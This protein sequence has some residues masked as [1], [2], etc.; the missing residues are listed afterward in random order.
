MAV[1]VG[2]DFAL[3]VTEDGNICSCGDNW[4][5]QLGIGDFELHV[6]PCL[7]KYVDTFDGHEVVMVAARESRS[8]CVTK[9]GTLWTWGYNGYGVLGH[10]HPFDWRDELQ[11]RPRRLSASLLGDSPVLMAAY[12]KAFLLILTSSGHVWS[13]GIGMSYELGHGSAEVNVVP[14][15]IDPAVFDNAEI[16]MIAAGSEHCIALSKTGGKVWGWGCNYASQTGVHNEFVDETTQCVRT[17]TLIPATDLQGGSVVFVS[18]GWDSS[19]LVT[20]D[21]VLWMCGDNDRYG[22]GMGDDIAGSH[23]FRR[24]GGAEFFGTGIRMVA[25]GMHHTMILANDNTVWTCGSGECGEL[26]RAPNWN[27]VTAEQVRKRGPPCRID[28]TTFYQSAPRGLYDNDAAVVAVGSY[29]SF[30]ITNGGTVYFW[31]CQPRVYFA[32]EQQPLD[33]PAWGSFEM[34]APNLGLAD[35]SVEYA[36]AGLWHYMHQDAMIAFV[37]GT[38]SSFAADTPIPS[39]STFPPEM[40]RQLFRNMRLA[41]REPTSPGVRAL[42]GIEDDE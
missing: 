7:L 33:R 31:G 34:P 8:A 39:N 12:G 20:V 18:C 15:R 11:C 29:T 26:A 30:V 40:L 37:M 28:A 22:S 9:D 17:P 38:E 41:P 36:R 32:Y 21:G 16:G 27:N 13:L 3:I 14:R 2:R 1:A 10:P 24:I 42:L 35:N 6:Q 19:A 5:G 4:Y 25:C 23:V